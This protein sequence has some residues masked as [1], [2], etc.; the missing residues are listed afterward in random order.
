MSSNLNDSYI[1]QPGTSTKKIVNDLLDKFGW[2]GGREIHIAVETL[3]RKEFCVKPEVDFL[4][5]FEMLAEITGSWYFQDEFGTFWFRDPQAIDDAIS[6]DG[7]L[8]NGSERTSLIGYCNVVQVIGGSVYSSWEDGS[9]I[10]SQWPTIRAIVA[11]PAEELEAAGIIM[12]PP[13]FIPEANYTQCKEI[14][15]NLLEFYRNKRDNCKPK[16][17][18]IVPRLG[19]IVYYTPRNG[20]LGAATCDS[21]EKVT[22]GTKFGKVTGCVVKR[23]VDFSKDGLICDLEVAT[24]ISVTSGYVPIGKGV[25]AEDMGEGITKLSEDKLKQLLEGLA[26]GTVELDDSTVTVNAAPE[27]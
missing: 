18:G 17:L 24:R 8:L 13:V 15:T 23:I 14:A 11:A 10:P 12:A 20:Y 27:D 5:A 3:P 22:E 1:A 6:L 4:G 26:D 9:E 2:T 21:D 25:K 19:S 16:V 7:N